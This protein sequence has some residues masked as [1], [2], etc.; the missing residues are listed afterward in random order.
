MFSPACHEYL[1][2]DTVEEEMRFLS[3]NCS[4]VTRLGGARKAMLLG[5]CD[6]NTDA[7]RREVV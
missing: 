4:F 1:R 3:T 2:L 5:Y 7:K 6:P